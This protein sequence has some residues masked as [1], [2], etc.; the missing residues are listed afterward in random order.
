MFRPK[1]ARLQEPAELQSDHPGVII[2]ND[3]D[4]FESG[5]GAPKRLTVY[6]ID[7]KMMELSKTDAPQWITI[8]WTAQLNDPISLSLHQAIQNNFNVQYLY[9]Y[10]FDP[11]KVKGQPYKPLRSPAA[12]E[13]VTAGKLS[14]AA[15]RVPDP[16]VH[17][18]DDF[19][20]G[21][22]GK[23]P[24]NWNSTLD[25]TGASSVVTTVDG[26]TGQWASMAG[27]HITPTGL[28]TPL[29]RDFDLSYDVVAAKDYR[30]GARGLTM[31]LSKA[32]AA[33]AGESFLN[34]RIRPG[35]SGREGELVIEAVSGA[36]S[37][38]AGRNLSPRQVFERPRDQPR[39][40]RSKR[41][42]VAGDR[43][44]PIQR[45]SRT[46]VRLA[47]FRAIE[48]EERCSSATSDCEELMPVIAQT[49]VS[50]L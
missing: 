36:L 27:M 50:W 31:R 24:L 9:D 20:S 40:R 49:A 23:K 41:R 22:V 6:A 33:G 44:S 39:H 43:G 37:P 38:W 15:T 3:T 30:W 14:E 16:A 35:F 5:G 11:E 2:E 28:K 25:N 18:F 32:P 1:H 34:L 17:F 21:T 48:R 19:S 47:V 26:L 7:P 10:F 46:A 4:V 12:V 45:A 42:P 8:S 13:V 29:P